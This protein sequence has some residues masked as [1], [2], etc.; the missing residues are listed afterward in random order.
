[1][2]WRTWASSGCGSRLARSSRDIIGAANQ[3]A[4]QEW[5]IICTPLELMEV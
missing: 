5:P 2:R 4:T 1:M 3:Q